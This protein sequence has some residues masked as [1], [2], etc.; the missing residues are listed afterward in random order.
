MIPRWMRRRTNCDAGG[1]FDEAGFFE[2]EVRDGEEG[3][4]EA[5]VEGVVCW[6]RVRRWW[7]FL[8]LFGGLVVGLEMGKGLFGAEAGDVGGCD[9][10][11]ESGEMGESEGSRN[12]SGYFDLADF[13]L[14]GTTQALQEVSTKNQRVLRRVNGMNP[15]GWDD[16]RVARFQLHPVHIR[17]VLLGL[18]PIS[19]GGGFWIRRLCAEVA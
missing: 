14:H 7:G 5:G 19:G 8:F 1:M 12:F 2:E 9:V 13:E 16:H 17:V 6:A 10:P 4:K 18:V 3:A 15:P 11:A